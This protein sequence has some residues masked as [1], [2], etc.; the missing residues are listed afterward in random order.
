MKDC[1][2]EPSTAFTSAAYL[3]PGEMGNTGEGSSELDITKLDSF[4]RP[5]APGLTS[6]EGSGAPHS[7]EQQQPLTAG[8]STTVEIPTATSS[9]FTRVPISLDS[10]EE[11]DEATNSTSGGQRQVSGG[12]QSPYF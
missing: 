7:N 5:F 12:Q 1:N 8:H 10:D 3:Q 9:T 6:G 11:D 4:M 2:M